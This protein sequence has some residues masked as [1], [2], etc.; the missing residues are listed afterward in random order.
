M[1]WNQITKYFVLY[2][3][4]FNYI[5]LRRD[6]FLQKQWDEAPVVMVG[7]TQTYNITFFSN[8]NWL[9]NILPRT[10]CT[11]LPGQLG[12]VNHW[13]EYLFLCIHAI[14][15]QIH[16]LIHYLVFLTCIRKC[17]PLLSNLCT[18]FIPGTSWI[19]QKY[20]N[21]LL[22]LPLLPHVKW[23]MGRDASRKIWTIPFWRPLVTPRGFFGPQ[24]LPRIFTS[25]LLN[26]PT[27]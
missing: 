11:F 20:L 19:N 6:L 3:F 24:R 27:V 10:I 5:F 15:R 1:I 25:N 21:M 8:P 12:V 7:I 9:V 2:V 16:S 18:V 23:V 22:S 14:Y 17:I 13:I 26:K 4:L